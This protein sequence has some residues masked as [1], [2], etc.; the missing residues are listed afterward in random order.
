MTTTVDKYLMVGC[1]DPKVSISIAGEMRNVMRGGNIY[2]VKMVMTSQMHE[3]INKESV[4]FGCVTKWKYIRVV[5][6]LIGIM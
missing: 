1:C 6:G 2:I 5:K 4:K 3:Y